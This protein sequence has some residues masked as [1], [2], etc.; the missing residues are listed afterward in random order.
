MTRSKRLL[1]GMLALTLPALLLGF[2]PA[3]AQAGTKTYEVTVTNINRQ[4]VSDPEWR[5]WA[6][7]RIPLN[8]LGQPEDLVGAIVFLASDDSAYVTGTTLVVDGG[9][10]AR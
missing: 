4:R 2:H 8:R 6:L 1:V 3:A 10:L 7:D 5:R 9:Y